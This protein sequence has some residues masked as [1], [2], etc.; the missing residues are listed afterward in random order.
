MEK[1][2]L[3]LTIKKKWFD[4]IASG[5]KKTEYREIKPHWISRFLNDGFTKVFD[6]IHF[7]NGYTLRCPFMIVKWKGLDTEKYNGKNHFAI[8]LGRIIAIRNNF[9]VRIKNAT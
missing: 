5:E 1:R 6:E 2:I 8:R 7:R 3:H 9:K 4:A